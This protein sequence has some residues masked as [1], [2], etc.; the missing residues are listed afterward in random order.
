ME[1]FS[2]KVRNEFRFKPMIV[3]PFTMRCFEIWNSVDI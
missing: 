3:I 1:L 2:L